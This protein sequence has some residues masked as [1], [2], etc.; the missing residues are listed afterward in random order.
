V[1]LNL[2]GIERL[3]SKWSLPGRLFYRLGEFLATQLPDA[4]V[5]DA[6]CI[7]DYYLQEYGFE[8][9]MIAYGAAVGG[10]DTQ[11][12]LSRLTLRR[13][14]YVLFVSRLEPENNAHRVVE[15]YRKAAIEIPLVLLGDAPYGG[16]YIR[17]LRQRAEGLNVILPGAIYG[18]G[19][20]ELLSHCRC[21]IQ[22][23]EVG[24]THPA[25]IEAMGAGCVVLANDTPENRE[26]VGEGGLLYPFNDEWE[27]SRL[28]RHVCKHPRDYEGLARKAQQRV[29][30]CYSW[31]TVVRQYEELFYDIL[32]S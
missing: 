23:T 22:A 25:L 9:R 32:G 17:H 11:E 7:R 13:N 30:A 20:R 12:A 28:L 19:Y 29:K 18:K 27:L 31:D 2:D 6:H 5:S 15:A 21:F 24:G 3:R 1:V 10:E 14:R 26:V 8:T 16:R 4:A